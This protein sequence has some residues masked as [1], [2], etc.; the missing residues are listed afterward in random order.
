MK[1]AIA[2]RERGKKARRHERHCA[3]GAC[4]S[5]TGSPSFSEKTNHGEEGVLAS[6]LRPRA[7]SRLRLMTS[8]MAGGVVLVALAHAED[9]LTSRDVTHGPGRY[10]RPGTLLAARDVTRGPGRYSRPGTLLT[11]RDVTHG[12]GRPLEEEKAARFPSALRS[13]SSAF[14]SCSSSSPAPSAAP[15]AARWR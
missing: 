15:A 2:D 6:G 9:L 11:A 14:R 8:A 5:L 7:L 10:S 12:P 3:S 1:N 13:R 4:S